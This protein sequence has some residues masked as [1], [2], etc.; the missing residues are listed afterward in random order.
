M[1]V[2]IAE[3]A[4]VGQHQGRVSLVPKRTVVAE[5][6]LVDFFGQANREQRH[7]S[8]AAFEA[9]AE[10]P[11]ELPRR[12]VADG[13]EEVAAFGKE[14]MQ[15]FGDR[16]RDGLRAFVQRVVA[17]HFETQHTDDLVASLA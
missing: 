6:D 3:V 9:S 12:H 4:G 15:P 10:L 14:P 5:P 16:R 17:D 1:V 2:W 7:P 8:G 13:G 11:V